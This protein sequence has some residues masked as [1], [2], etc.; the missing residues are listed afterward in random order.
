MGPRVR[1]DADRR[2]LV[3][4]V[5]LN[6]NDH[7]AH[8]QPDHHVVADR[9]AALTKASVADR[10]PLVPDRRV[11][12]EP[13]GQTRAPDAVP[14]DRPVDPAVL[15]AD[16]IASVP[17][18]GDQAGHDPS[19]TTRNEVAQPLTPVEQELASQSGGLQ[20]AAGLLAR[21]ARPSPLQSSLWV[22]REMAARQL[23]AVRWAVVGL[24]RQ[25][26]ALGLALQS[27][28]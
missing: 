23:A 24:V 8:V 16:R 26:S 28:G 22:G 1:L 6:E 17:P 27:G 19:V 15:A 7:P 10:V 14:A 3:L 21:A 9:D 25:S 2:D 12:V 5:A 18:R 13:A 4:I 11:D 20:V